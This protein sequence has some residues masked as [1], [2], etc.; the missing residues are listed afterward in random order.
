[1]VD[2]EHRTAGTVIPSLRWRNSKASTCPA[3]R[4]PIR[5]TDLLGQ[6]EDLGWCHA[7]CADT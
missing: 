4:L 2:H 5:E 6:V 1:M 3:C 7:F